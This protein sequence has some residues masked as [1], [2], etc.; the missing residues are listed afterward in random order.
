MPETDADLYGM[1]WEEA[2]EAIEQ[3]D[4]A[5][6]P[7]GSIEQHSTHLP[8]STDTLRSDHLTAEL[9]DAADEFDLE[10]LRLPPLPY[11]HSEHHMTF[12]GTVSLSVSTYVDVL[13]EIGESLAEHGVDRLLIANFHGGN[14]DSLSVA[15]NRLVRDTD[16][17]VHCVHWTEFARDDLREEFGEGWGHAGDHETSF[18]ELYRPDLV[19]AEKKEPQNAAEMPKTGTYEYFSDVTELGGLGDPTNSDPE[20]MERIVADATRAILSAVVEDVENGW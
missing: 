9:V 18:V 2:G 16:M 8:V 4:L 15:A 1:T 10:L 3:A 13:R 20:A 7:T 11:G 19:K 6:L 12:P 17:A 14:R 5:V